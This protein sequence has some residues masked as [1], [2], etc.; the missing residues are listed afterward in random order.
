MR[1]LIVYAI[2]ALSILLKPFNAIAQCPFTAT[3]SP[4]NLILCPQ[5]TGEL[6]LTIEPATY[7]SVK[8]FKWL[9]FGGFE[10]EEI[11]DWENQLVVNLNQ[12]DHSG[13]SFYAQ[14]YAG[15]CNEYS[16]TVLVDGYIFLPP[17]VM[18]GGSAELN[19]NGVWEIAC[20]QDATL[21]L[22]MPYTNS[23]VWY[24]NGTPLPGE[25]AQV[26]N[27]TQSGLYTV[28]G[29]PE[30]CP[31]L[32]S[33]LGLELE[34]V[35][36]PD[37]ELSIGLSGNQLTASSGN[38]WQWYLN[39]DEIPGATEQVYSAITEGYYQV[40]ASFDANCIVLSDSFQVT[41]T[42]IAASIRHNLNLG[43]N[44]CNDVLRIEGEKINQNSCYEIISI[45]G[46]LMRKGRLMQNAI[47][48]SSLPSG[49][50]ALRIIEGNLYPV[51][52]RF[53]KTN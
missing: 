45:D 39:G 52:L 51:V 28:S 20:G 11:T 24:R 35:V 48:V 26:L 5:G 41:T 50:Y 21:E 16:D 2:F 1:H 43:P 4:D 29:A 40:E 25:N 31:D 42:G 30:L 7:D 33:F 49:Q 46:Q 10:E 32:I 23:I 36:L 38:A 13:Y 47:N 34:Y 22:M 19:Q 18:H 44:P 3:L 27:I 15:D 9:S 12:F 8:W 14:V 17:V 6:N 53:T 37:P